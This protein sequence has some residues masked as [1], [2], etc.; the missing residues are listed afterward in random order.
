MKTPWL[1]AV[2]AEKAC[3]LLSIVTV[4]ETSKTSCHSMLVGVC[5]LAIACQT[6]WVQVTSLLDP[7]MQDVGPKLGGGGGACSA[8]V[9]YLVLY[10][11]WNI[12]KD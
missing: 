10:S 11:I 8:V 1:E 4:V 12:G 7:Y 5:G 9:I 3:V 2:V 6:H